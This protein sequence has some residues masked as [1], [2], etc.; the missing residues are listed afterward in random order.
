MVRKKVYLNCLI[1]VSKVPD[2]GLFLNE[3]SYSKEIFSFMT[4]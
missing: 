1:T 4:F 2:I 3:T